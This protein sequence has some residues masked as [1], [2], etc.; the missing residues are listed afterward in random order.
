MLPLT[1]GYSDPQLDI[2]IFLGIVTG[3][4]SKQ[5]QSTVMSASSWLLLLVLSQTKTQ[6]LIIFITEENIIKFL[7]HFQHIVQ[8]AVNKIFISKSHYI[9]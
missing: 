5:L 3:H 6:I 2:F 7:C 1:V 9:L 4:G 8:K